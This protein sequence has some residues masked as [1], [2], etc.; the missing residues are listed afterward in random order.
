MGFSGTGQPAIPHQPGGLWERCK[1]LSGVRGGAP[2]AEKFSC[3]LGRQTAFPSISV[4]VA[5]SLHG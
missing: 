4:R 3:T 2:A 1:L 5:Y